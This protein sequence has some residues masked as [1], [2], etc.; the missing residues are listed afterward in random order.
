[1]TVIVRSGRAV[2]TEESPRVRE[3]ELS[4]QGEDDGGAV[5]EVGVAGA[6]G[7]S[8]DCPH[9]ADEGGEQHDGAEAFGEGE[10]GR[11]GQY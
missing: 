7:Q 5:G 8:T 1:M 6:D 3:D 10:G 2:L 11:A 4:D 9:E